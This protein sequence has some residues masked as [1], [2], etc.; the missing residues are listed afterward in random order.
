MRKKSRFLR[1]A[2]WRILPFFLLALALAVREHL[3]LCAAFAVLALS[4]MSA[5]FCGGVASYRFERPGARYIR[6]KNKF[7]R[8][9]LVFPFHIRQDFSTDEQDERA[10]LVGLVLGIM[11]L[12]LLFACLFLLCLFPISGAFIVMPVSN[13]YT[14]L[15]GCVFLGFWFAFAHQLKK[16]EAETEKGPKR[17]P[18]ESIKRYFSLLFRRAEKGK[19]P[20]KYRVCRAL[21]CASLVL[22]AVAILALCCFGGD[23]SVRG[24]CVCG[25]LVFGL[26]TLL[27]AA[28]CFWLGSQEATVAEWE[29]RDELRRSLR[30]LAVRR[31]EKSGQKRKYW[32]RPDQIPA[33]EERVK[34]HGVGTELRYA[35]GEGRILS[36]SVVVREDER[37]VFCG[38]FLR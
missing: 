26:L 10:N 25:V 23:D 11:N 5:G 31:Q 15:T 6:I 28:V 27:L 19:L 2:E 4:G 36:F 9:I 24:L 33:I 12:F 14:S 32:Y 38:L 13:L 35:E 16:R 17:K 30:E 29:W 22:D 34:E 21:F 37:V 18:L 8:K 3:T 7:F 1:E 20:L